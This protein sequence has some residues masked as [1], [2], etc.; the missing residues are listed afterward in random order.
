[1]ADR[2]RLSYVDLI[3]S[4]MSPQ[5]A[6]GIIENER[7]SIT[8]LQSGNNLSD[9]D[10]ASSG[11]ANLGLGTIAI[12][13]G[14]LSSPAAGELL[15]YDAT[16][17]R[18]ENASLAAGSGISVANADASVTVAVDESAVDHDA[19]QNVVA[20]EHIDHS[21]VSISSGDG[22]SG[23]GDITASRTLNVDIN[24]ATDLGSPAAAD[25]LLLS[26]V[27]N[28]NA[29]RKSDIDTI[30]AIYDD[31]TATLT[32]KA[33]DANGTGNNLSNV[34]T[35]DVAPAAKTGSD[36]SFVTGTAGSD[37]NV[38]EWN[39]DGDAVDSGTATATLEN[40][41]TFIM[42]FGANLTTAGNFMRANGEAISNDVNSGVSSKHVTRGGTISELFFLHDGDL[43]SNNATLKIQ[44]N[45]AVQAT[46]TAS[47]GS[48]TADHFTAINVS[49][50]DGDTVEIEFDAGSSNPEDSIGALLVV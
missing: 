29:V 11:R 8:A 23:G 17:S 13:D 19:L 7:N 41:A 1:M 12:I 5:A 47:G 42:S 27:D 43:S 10:S 22:L 26:D 25:E 39:A 32:N 14:V 21:A 4:G 35:D 46:L 40:K 49:V 28:A 34:E 15:I 3:Q 30:L 24:G 16:D 44:V 36:T 50:N 9:V 48:A 6:R 18:F 37:G 45:G 38:A 33:F 31:K 2:A 20:D